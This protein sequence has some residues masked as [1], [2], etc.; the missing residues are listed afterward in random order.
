M[1]KFVEKCAAV[2]EYFA[3]CL[4]VRS[5]LSIYKVA[6]FSWPF[7]PIFFEI[8]LVGMFFAVQINRIGCLSSLH[9]RFFASCFSIKSFPLTRI[10]RSLQTSSLVKKVYYTYTKFHFLKNYLATQSVQDLLSPV[11]QTHTFSSLQYALDST[12]L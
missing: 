12:A 3:P 11:L 9:S 10:L 1:Y 2:W 6:L 4:M 7:I 5:E 8:S